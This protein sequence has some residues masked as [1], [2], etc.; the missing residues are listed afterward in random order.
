M[1]I[2][3]PPKQPD[4]RLAKAKVFDYLS[5]YPRSPSPKYL[6]PRLSNSCKYKNCSKI[7]ITVITA[8]EGIIK[9]SL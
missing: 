9:T 8:A 4:S 5:V 2:G 6:F 3:N 1:Q 7:K